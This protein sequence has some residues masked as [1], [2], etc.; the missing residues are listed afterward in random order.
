MS[1]NR[2]A[3]LIFC[4]LSA[5]YFF[6][7]LH[8][9]GVAVIALDI[10]NEF[11]TDASLLGLMS[12][13]YFFHYAVAQI[14]VGIMLDRIGIRKT[15]SML[16]L[17]ACVGS[18]L[19]SLSPSIEVLTLGRA[20]VGFGV[21]GFY[22]SSLK[23]IAVWFKPGRFATLTG[24]LTAIGNIGGLV[25]SSPLALLSLALGWRYSFLLIS[26]FMLLFTGVAW[27]VIK[28]ED[29]SSFRSQGSIM[30]DLRTVFSKGDFLK[31]TLVPLFVY[32]YFI[33][34]QGLW[35]GPFLMDVYGMSKPTAGNFLLFIALGFMIFLPIA[36]FISDKIQRRKPV[37]ITG[38]LL[39]LLFWGIMYAAGRSMG[40]YE[41]MSMLFLLGT[42]FGFSNIYMTVSKEL[43]TT[44][45]CGTAM[46]CYNTFA[47]IGAGFFQY[48]MGFLLDITYGGT[49]IFA[50]YQLIFLIG[51]VLIALS[52]IVAILSKE[53]FS[54]AP[55]CPT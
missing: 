10:M 5:L 32:G 19:F 53:T 55:V 43:F 25:A 34:F 18:I 15:V 44:D 9:V 23:A 16:S 49:R 35:G 24:V 26:F 33:S 51:V 1:K 45:I 17:V 48:F 8:R 11:R 52:L 21:G 2:Y 46:A 7:I 50:S 40:A 27:F 47:F 30:C 42:S 39:S 6:S 20:M 31:L 36:G 12:S 38:I 37:L 3:V 41:L 22:V 28:E 14:P 29:A 13:M 54:A 4:S